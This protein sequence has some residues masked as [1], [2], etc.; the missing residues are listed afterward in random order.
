[1]HINSDGHIRAING[2]YLKLYKPSMNEMVLKHKKTKLYS[3]KTKHWLIIK[4][5]H[6]SFKKTKTERIKVLQLKFVKAIPKV[7]PNS[8]RNS[9]QL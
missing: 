7:I 9:S 4:F 3:Y 2:K 6:N 1:M 8:F 5:L